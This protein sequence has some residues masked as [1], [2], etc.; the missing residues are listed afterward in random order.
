MN[1]VH[2][3]SRYGL[4]FSV[5]KSSKKNNS[6]IVGVARS[7]PL[8]YFVTPWIQPSGRILILYTVQK[9]KHGDQGNFSIE[10]GPQSSLLF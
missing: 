7:N 2:S 4:A 3:A 9:I 6:T 5:C 8:Y 10:F 1:Q